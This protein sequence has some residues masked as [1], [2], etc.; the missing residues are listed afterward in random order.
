MPDLFIND[1]INKITFLEKR[2]GAYVGYKPM[3][4]FWI[5]G[6]GFTDSVRLQGNAKGTTGWPVGRDGHCRYYRGHIS[7]TAEGKRA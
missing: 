3:E 4:P 5:P 2:I 1:Y 7:R 6:K